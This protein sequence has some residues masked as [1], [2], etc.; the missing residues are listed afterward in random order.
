MMVDVTEPSIS[1]P[2]LIKRAIDGDHQ[3]FAQLI[4][5]HDDR[6]RAVAYQMMSDRH[7]MDDVLQMSY[8]KAFRKLTS[9]RAE[10]S[11]SSWL[12]R[13]VVNV[14]LDEI[15]KKQRKAEVSL[16]SV[17]NLISTTSIEDQYATSASLHSALQRLSPDM[18]SVVI[19]VDGQGLSY[20]EAALA[21]DTQAGTIASRLSRA[22]TALRQHL[23]LPKESAQ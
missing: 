17:A 10:A 5:S 9:F 23:G 20:E 8:L 7:A 2:D 11:F 3:S 22:R 15:R 13:I 12:H 14:C 4:Q 6:M 19:L 1:D 18:R 16:E 21:L